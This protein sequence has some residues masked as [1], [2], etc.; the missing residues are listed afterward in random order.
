MRQIKRI[1][2]LKRGRYRNGV[3]KTAAGTIGA[4]II[5]FVFSP[6]VPTLSMDK[7]FTSTAAEQGGLN[8]W[9]IWTTLFKTNETRGIIWV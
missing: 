9:K 4:V 6:S 5:G 8:E 1:R 7:K 3:M 2:L